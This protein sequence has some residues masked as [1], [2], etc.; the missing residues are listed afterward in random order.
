MMTIKQQKFLLELLWLHNQKSNGI[1]KEILK[2]DI[3]SN[4]ND[5]FKQIKE[6]ELFGYIERKNYERNNISYC[7]TANGYALSNILAK[8]NNT[9]ERFRKIAKGIEWW[10]T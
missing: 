6:L 3:F 2:K 10:I 9:D 4:D 7:L 5:F 1:R 8:Q